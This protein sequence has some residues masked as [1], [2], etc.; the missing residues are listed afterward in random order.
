[1][2]S[3]FDI[4][5]KYRYY[6]S[7]GC[8]QYR[9]TG[10]WYCQSRRWFLRDKLLVWSS[11]HAVVADKWFLY[12]FVIAWA[13]AWYRPKINKYFCGWWNKRGIFDKMEVG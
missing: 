2:L 4:I 8:N 13:I 10:S 7:S 11:D 6:P 1:M 3:K 5:Y 12:L 9:S